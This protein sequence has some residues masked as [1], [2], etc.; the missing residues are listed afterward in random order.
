MKVIIKEKEYD[1][2]SDY[3]NGW[4]FASGDPY[5]FPVTIGKYT[6][7]V[8]RFE[9]KSPE[10]ISGWDLLLQLKGKFDPNLPRIYDIVE[11]EENNKFI[12]YIFYEFLTGETLEAAVNRNADLDLQRLTQDLFT[13]AV[14]L[15]ARNFWFSDFCEKNIF[16]ESSG[17]FLLIDLDS[18]QPNAHLPHN[19]MYGDKQYWALV[20]NFY[21]I[22]LGYKDLRPADISGPMLNYLQIVFLI[23]RLKIALSDK[24]FDYKA[25]ELYDNLPALLAD[26]AGIFPEIFR[27]A[28]TEK[29]QAPELLEPHEVQENIIRHIAQNNQVPYQPTQRL[30]EILKFATSASQVEPGQSFTLSWEVAHAHQLALYRNGNLYQE[31]IPETYQLIIKENYDGRTRKVE[32]TLRA[33]SK[34]GEQ[35][36]MPVTITIAEKVIPEPALPLEQTEQQQEN[37][38]SSPITEHV[39]VD[40]PEPPILNPL[41]PDKPAAPIIWYFRSDAKQVVGGQSLILEWEVEP[42]TQIT[43]YRNNQVYARNLKNQQSLSVPEQYNAATTIIS[44]HLVAANN[45]VQIKSDALVV[46]VIKPINP[47][48]SRLRYIQLAVL[49]LFLAIL[50]IIAVGAYSLFF[51]KNLKVYAVANHATEGDTLAIAGENFTRAAENVRVFFNKQPGTVLS[52]SAK[53]LR[54][55]VPVVN[56][57]SD[58]TPVTLAL[59]IDT[60]TVYTARQFVVKRKIT[61]NTPPI[62]TPDSTVIP[63]KPKPD[64]N[65][66]SQ[67]ENKLDTILAEVA[68]P[69]GLGAHSSNPGNKPEKLDK[70]DKTSKPG[71]TPPHSKPDKPVTLPPKPAP[72]KP[73]PTTHSSYTGTLPPDIY[74]LVTV[75]SNVVINQKRDGTKNLQITVQNS[76]A[77]NLDNVR[78]EIE[79]LR[80][81]DKFL[82]KEIL[83]FVRVRAHSS[84]TL[85][86]PDNEKAKKANFKI[87]AINGQA[88]AY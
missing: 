37:R 57:G 88:T 63:P 74:K 46:Q 49:V 43:L 50:G 39:L 28:L 10:D 58:I 19:S 48:P 61:L 78:V 42:A 73:Q 70:P 72:E 33:T 7:F 20:L 34:A 83:T 2:F 71:Q 60:D 12:H 86:A 87:V 69:G 64:N 9:K 32:F 82:K 67:T 53:L 54:V 22:Q 44:Y 8:K 6:C 80:R 62:T 59:L 38:Q 45:Q 79:Y 17:R 55:V 3:P 41:N 75:K 24:R 51:P 84:Q 56:T 52:L 77:Y 66:I 21:K 40:N 4:L 26:T 16:K 15:H 81:N 27:R 5:K 18:V 35:S 36:S 47:N 1:Y 30:P 25:T 29:Q 76:S 13:A 23:L 31:V 68:E 85:A 14:A 11:V 65:L